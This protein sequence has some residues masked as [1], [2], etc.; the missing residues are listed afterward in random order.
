MPGVQRPPK[1]HS[2]PHGEL[3]AYTSYI[4]VI[5]IFKYI[6][7]PASGILL[8]QHPPGPVLENTEVAFTCLTYKIKPP[9]NLVWKLGEKESSDGD[10]INE[11]WP[12]S[13]E[14]EGVLILRLNKAM[15]NQV[16]QCYVREKPKV[17]D[18]LTLKFKSKLQF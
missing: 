11:R 4:Y 12:S 17:K 14:K 16:V 5:K 13:E 3:V 10:T 18:A 15:N 7:F 8:S 6:L 9:I 2:V 1:K